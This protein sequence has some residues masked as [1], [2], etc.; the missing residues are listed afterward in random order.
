M[1]ARIK[2]L[3]VDLIECALPKYNLLMD[4]MLRRNMKAMGSSLVRL[5]APVS[6]IFLEILEYAFEDR[7]CPINGNRDDMIV[8]EYIES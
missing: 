6:Q 8:C 3:S 4:A 2:R 5:S 7:I 1:S